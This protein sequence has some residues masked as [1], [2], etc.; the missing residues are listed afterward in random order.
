[1]LGLHGFCGGVH[2]EAHGCM[3]RDAPLPPCINI[4]VDVCGPGKRPWRQPG[5]GGSSSQHRS[6]PPPRCT[7]PM[8]TSVHP[9]T[10]V[11]LPPSPPWPT[12]PRASAAAVPEDSLL[13]CMGVRSRDPHPRGPLLQ[14]PQVSALA[15]MAPRAPA[16][17]PG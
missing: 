8:K 4:H 7:H 13:T 9:R 3:G 16:Q 6:S 11:E 15:V 12:G 1:M 10:A 14:E 2:G 17:Q 5:A